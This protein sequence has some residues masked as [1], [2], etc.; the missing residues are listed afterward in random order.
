MPSATL[1]LSSSSSLNHRGLSHSNHYQQK[2]YPNDRGHKLAAVTV[3]QL[4][5]IKIDTSTVF[6]GITA[7][8]VERVGRSLIVLKPRP[9]TSAEAKK[10]LELLKQTEIDLSFS[11]GEI[12]NLRDFPGSNAKGGNVE[13][14]N[15]LD[16]TGHKEPEVNPSPSLPVNKRDGKG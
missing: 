12:H 2:K 5:V 11:T 9:A 3:G 7:S 4:I 16:T 8:S 10:I 6:I 1:H 14:K 15:H 13:K